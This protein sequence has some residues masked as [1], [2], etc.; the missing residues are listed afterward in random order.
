MLYD[1]YAK[2]AEAFKKSSNQKYKQIN[3]ELL[4][5]IDNYGASTTYLNRM[6]ELLGIKLEEQERLK[7]EIDLYNSKTQTS[8]R[9]VVYEDRE[10]DWL[11][12]FRKILLFVYFCILLLY[13]IV[14]KFIPNKE[15]LQ[16]KMWLVIFV[17]IL[18]PF[19]LLDRIVKL[20]FA[21]FSY[22]ASWRLRK[23]FMGKPMP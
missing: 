12:T 7:R 17:Y 4:D 14:G 16:W 13:I 6:N 20:V 9:K 15:Y 5:M 22:L 3:D 18:S 10:R 2:T 23:M 1:R 21:L 8:G 19:F 11:S